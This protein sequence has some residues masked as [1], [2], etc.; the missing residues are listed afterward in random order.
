VKHFAR[1]ISRSISDWGRAFCF[2]H[3]ANTS[4]Y[5]LGINSSA[6][7]YVLFLLTVGPSSTFSHNAFPLFQYSIL[8]IAILA[9]ELTAAG[10]AINYKTEVCQAIKISTNC[11]MDYGCL[12]EKF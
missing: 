4:I 8:V 11:V 10:L 7:F 12:S 3:S 2:N 9:L 1:K 5:V 6:I